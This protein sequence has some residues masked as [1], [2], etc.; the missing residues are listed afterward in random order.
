MRSYVL[1]CGWHFATLV[2]LTAILLAAPVGAEE[3]PAALGS[4]TKQPLPA[5]RV[6]AI[7]FHRTQRC[8]TC[9]RIGGYIEEAIKTGFPGQVKDGS[10]AVYM[11][12]YENPR[13]AKY[14][15]S[16]KVSRPTLVLADIHNNK[17]VAWKPMP[18]VWSL[19]YKKDDFFKYVHDGVK[20]YF[21]EKKQ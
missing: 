19:V 18:K 9:R 17:V 6:A 20:D 7:Y 11:V 5:H 13:N 21:K 3:Q 15:K 1:A 16:Y 14:T 4:A 10:V 12:D 8:P 2:G